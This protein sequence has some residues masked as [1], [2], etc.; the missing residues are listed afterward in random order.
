MSQPARSSRQLAHVYPGFSLSD[1]GFKSENKGTCIIFI[2]LFNLIFEPRLAWNDEH[3]QP[4][5]SKLIG[6]GANKIE[7]LAAILVAALAKACQWKATRARSARSS[8]SES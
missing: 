7:A 2:I 3:E 1:G 5:A 4:L 8:E 6:T